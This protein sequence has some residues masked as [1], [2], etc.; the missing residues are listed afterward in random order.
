MASDLASPPAASY[1]RMYV[2]T[3]VVETDGAHLHT[4]P[5]ITQKQW[6]GRGGK[7]TAIQLY[8]VLIVLIHFHAVGDP[9]NF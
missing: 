6:A 9:K 3:Y 7:N 2:C 5:S 4:P 1:I 8:L